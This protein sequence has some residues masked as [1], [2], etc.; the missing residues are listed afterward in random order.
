MTGPRKAD[1]SLPPTVK[2]PVQ[3]LVLY[4]MALGS[5]SPAARQ[6]GLPYW[7]TAKRSLIIRHPLTTQD[8]Y[9]TTSLPKALPMIRFSCPVC[10]KVL[11]APDHGTGQK[12]SCP[13]CGQKLVVPPPFQ[14]ENRTILGLP[15]PSAADSPPVP[16]PTNGPVPV[17]D[18]PGC[19]EPLPVP[20]IPEWESPGGQRKLGPL[21]V[22]LSIVLGLFLVLLLVALNGRD[23][24]RPKASGKVK[25]EMADAS[26]VA[27]RKEAEAPK[28]ILPPLPPPLPNG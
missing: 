7:T 26:A 23:S 16:E 5:S 18:G 25:P 24:E 22:S 19:P 10:Q 28:P 27:P 12:C 1:Q 2:R 11:K 9:G 13:R 15:L 8:Q 3:P 20:V 6:W 21:L 14:F 4:R 17:E